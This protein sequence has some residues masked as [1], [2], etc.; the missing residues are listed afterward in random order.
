MERNLFSVRRALMA[1]LSSSRA[2]CCFSCEYIRF[3][4]SVPFGCI[5]ST[6]SGDFEEAATH[7]AGSPRR[8]RTTGLQ[9]RVLNKLRA[10][11]IAAPRSL[12]SSPGI[13][14]LLWESQD[15]R[16][17]FGLISSQIEVAGVYD[18][19]DCDKTSYLLRQKAACHF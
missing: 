3:G 15:P 17:I 1:C 14:T 7:D 8:R 16:L 4:C 19:C 11:A 6:C 13:H 2:T 12:L 18:A 9:M 5:Q 10:S